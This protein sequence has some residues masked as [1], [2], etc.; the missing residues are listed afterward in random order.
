M[1]EVELLLMLIVAN[2]A[3]VIVDRIMGDR[4]SWPIDGNKYLSDGYP[5]LGR[6]KTLRGLVSSCLLTMLL[7]L[8]LD[9]SAWHAFLFALLSM[10]GDMFSSFVKRR[11]GMRASSMAI[12]LDQ[13]PEALFPLVFL[14]NILLVSWQGMVTTVALFFVT[15][16]LLSAILYQLKIRKQ[17]Y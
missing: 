13:V 2:G 17:P 8:I 16:L 6:S 3:P 11:C 4:W 1:N 9:I 14:Q 15:E 10:T 5:L 12:G 7:S